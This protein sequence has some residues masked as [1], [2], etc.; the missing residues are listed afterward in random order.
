MA[1]AF[2][3][4]AMTYKATCPVKYRFTCE[5]CNHTTEWYESELVKTVS[6]V[7][8]LGR[9]KAQ[10]F[11]SINSLKKTE[12][13]AL[14]QLN[15]LISL[16]K[17]IDTST[18]TPSTPIIAQ[19]N[20]L[21]SKAKSCPMCKKR[22]SW[23]LT[24]A[25]NMPPNVSNRDVIWGKAKVEL[26]NQPDS[27]EYEV[28]EPVKTAAAFVTR[29]L[30]SISKP[31]DIGYWHLRK[32]RHDNILFV[33]N[34]FKHQPDTISIVEEKFESTP[35][36]D[37]METG[38]SEKEFNDYVLQLCDALDF[39]HNQTPPIVHNGILSYNILVGKDNLLKLTGFDDATIGGVFE[40]DIAMVGLLMSDIREKYISK[41]EDIIISCLDG[42]FTTI[43]ELRKNFLQ[44]NTSYAKITIVIIFVCLAIFLIS[45][46]IF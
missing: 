40:D 35:L 13:K 45:H 17:K 19:Y 5:S 29:T 33:L 38:I 34:I 3:T 12:E 46:R 31:E 6:N 26:M 44:V 8:N 2:G 9:F 21:F 4:S 25:T 43:K 39:L 37:L 22:Q 30:E 28:A 1:G 10:S 41:Y 14:Q 15:V 32:I 42:K 20:D 23:F 27:S 24:S 7:L 18:D 16:I 36:S 11:H